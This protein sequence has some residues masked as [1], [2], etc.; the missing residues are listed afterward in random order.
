[1]IREC[2]KCLHNDEYDKE[3]TF[4][5]KGVCNYCTKTSE[6]LDNV[7]KNFPLY[8]SVIQKIKS[9]KGKNGYDCILGMSGGVDSSY[10]AHIAKKEELNPLIVHFD[11]GWNTELSVD[12]I[13]KIIEKNKFDLH[14]LIVD[15]DEFKDIQKSVIK[16]GVVDIE[17]V[18]DHAIGATLFKLAKEKNIRYIISGSNVATE[19]VM[20]ASWSWSQRDFRNIKY[21][22]KKFGTKKIKTFPHFPIS[23]FL[24]KYSGNNIEF[25]HLLNYFPYKKFEAIKVLKDEYDWREYGGKHYES[26]FTKFYQAYI[27]PKKF[28]IDKRIA[29]LSALIRN[30]EITKEQA[31]IEIMKPII[32]PNELKRD[33]EYFCKKLEFSLAEFDEIMKMPPKN[34]NE[35]K[36]D[37]EISS[38]LMKIKKFLFRE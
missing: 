2:S 10:L 13:H 8:D 23:R 22:H 19:S 5:S 6:D 21:I 9:S 16:S 15:W 37:Y 1:M 33:L 32:E 20:P 26:F 24:G 27:L 25:I 18:T 35:Y 28:N 29:H 34:H 38:I 12:N 14:S 36:N 11:N 7:T 31:K 3:I 30:K 4:S 17:M